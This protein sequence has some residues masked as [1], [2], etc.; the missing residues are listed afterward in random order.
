[1][2]SSVFNISG[3]DTD[4]ILDNGMYNCQVNLTI[5]GNDTFSDVSDG[6]SVVLKG[7]VVCVYIL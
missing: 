4:G 2:M 7:K 1:M 6:S 3:N 5:A